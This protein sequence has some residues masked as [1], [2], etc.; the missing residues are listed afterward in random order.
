MTKFAALFA[1]TSAVF[2]SPLELWYRQPANLWVEA[3]PVG[4]GH[5]G[6]M[7]FGGISHER[8]QFNEQTVWAGEPHNYAHPGA[9]HYLEQIRQ[10][11]RDGKQAE[12][13]KPTR[14]SAICCS[15]SPASTTPPP[16]TTAARWIS[17]PPSLPPNSRRTASPIG[18][19]SFAATRPTCW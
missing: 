6:A 19:R 11:L 3:L 7:I 2:A 16:R 15:I 4:N 14:R 18:A 9:W 13:E 17:T 10:L 5:L 1:L 8:I 12:A